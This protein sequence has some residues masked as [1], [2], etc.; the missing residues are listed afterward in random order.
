MVG[1][2]SCINGQAQPVSKDYFKGYEEQVVDPEGE[3]SFMQLYDVA[4][5]HFNVVF[6]YEPHFHYNLK[7]TEYAVNPKIHYPNEGVFSK[8]YEKITFTLVSSDSE[9]FPSGT[10]TLNHHLKNGKDAFSL[11]VNNKTYQ[12]TKEEKESPIHYDPGVLGSF[13]YMVEDEKKFTM[14]VDV[15]VVDGLYFVYIVLKEGNLTFD[16]IDVE[17]LGKEIR[18]TLSGNADGTYLAN[19]MTASFVYHDE[20]VEEETWELELNTTIYEMTYI[21]DGPEPVILEGYF[22]NNF[23]TVSNSEFSMQIVSLALGDTAVTVLINELAEGGRKNIQTFFLIGD[24]GDS[25]TNLQGI[26]GNTVFQSGNTYKFVHSIVNESDKIDLYK[27]G[28]IF[29]SDLAIS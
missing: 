21:Q 14:D 11:K 26:V 28:V 9:L 13:A 18:F 1:V 19:E 12:L 8:D 6:L 29:Y 10:Y 4:D 2:S 5:N 16:A 25:L 23:V 22:Y 15:D 20:N 24:E 3:Y 7:I 27:N 17:E